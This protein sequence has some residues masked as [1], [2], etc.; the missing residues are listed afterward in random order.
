MVG[1]T[2][3]N[4]VDIGRSLQASNQKVLPV[5]NGLTPLQGIQSAYSEARPQNKL[6]QE[7]VRNVKVVAE[8][9]ECKREKLY[10]VS[11]SLKTH[12]NPKEFNGKFYRRWGGIGKNI[13]NLSVEIVVG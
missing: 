2:L 10:F 8:N 5:R 3:V 13:N 7:A 9:K 12:I 6:N 4:K 11:K 1:I